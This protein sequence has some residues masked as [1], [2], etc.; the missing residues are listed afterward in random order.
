MNCDTVCI[1]RVEYKIK[2]GNLAGLWYD[3][4]LSLVLVA[5]RVSA[6][7]DG[8]RPPR[9]H[10]RDALAQDGLAEYRA[11]QDVTDSTVRAQP[12]LF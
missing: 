8:L 4:V 6:D 7:D 3:K 5:V 2:I 1:L 10:A 9:H 11:A 12:H